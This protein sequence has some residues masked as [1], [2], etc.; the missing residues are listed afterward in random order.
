M[1]SSADFSPVTM[2]SSCAQ[3]PFS[4]SFSVTPGGWLNIALPLAAMLTNYDA[5]GTNG[6][7]ITSK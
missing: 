5:I 7:H 1:Y 4:E 3:A 6:I 2:T